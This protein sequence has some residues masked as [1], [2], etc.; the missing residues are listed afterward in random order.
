MYYHWQQSVST[1]ASVTFSSF[2][3]YLY[4]IL[5]DFQAATLSLSNEPEIQLMPGLQTNQYSTEESEEEQQPGMVEYKGQVFDKSE[6]YQ[7]NVYKLREELR[8]KEGGSVPVFGMGSIE[9]R[10]PVVR[11][12]TKEMHS[13]TKAFQDFRKKA[14]EEARRKSTEPSQRIDQALREREEK[15][16]PVKYGKPLCKLLL[17]YITF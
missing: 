17:T 9:S 15:E 8:Q 13:Q 16:Y 4:A 3:R 5:S 11:D 10:R 6:S 7:S 14:D 12:E 1:F 2:S